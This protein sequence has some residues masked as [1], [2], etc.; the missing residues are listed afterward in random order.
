MD[1]KTCSKCSKEYPATDEYF[2]KNCNYPD[3]LAKSCKHCDLKRMQLAR[4]KKNKVKYEQQ[5]KIKTELLA[6]GVKICSKCGKELPAT[7][8]YF[9]CNNKSE[10]GLR[11]ECKSCQQVLYAKYYAEKHRKEKEQ[12]NKTEQDLKIRGKKICSRCNN[13][14]DATLEFFYSMKSNKDNLSVWC[15][16]CC[17]EASK[18]YNKNNNELIKTKRK[19]WYEEN[20]NKPEYKAKRREYDNRRNKKQRFGRSFSGAINRALKGNKAEQH[21]EDLVPYNLEQLRQHLESQFTPEMN[22]DNYGNYWEVDHII[23]QSLFS[24]TTYQDEQFQICWSLANLR[25]LTVVENIQRPKDGSDISDDIR[26][27]ILKG[28]NK[29]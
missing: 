10:D 8:E 6:R 5:A 2:Y 1:S 7:K 11:C 20:K 9:Y 28:A 16:C 17:K 25:P 29:L 18:Q 26:Q 13:E 3:G 19:I 15:K 14:F 4:D 24:F 27:N 23:P 21:W 22:W 12:R